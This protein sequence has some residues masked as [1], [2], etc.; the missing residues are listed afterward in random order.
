[1]REGTDANSEPML[2]E[3]VNL[4]ETQSL[5]IEWRTE[6]ESTAFQEKKEASVCLSLAIILGEEGGKV[7]HHHYY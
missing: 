1:M 5:G 4:K 2:G 7:Q 6:I 3:R